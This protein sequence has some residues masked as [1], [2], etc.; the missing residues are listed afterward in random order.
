MPQITQIQVRRDTY[1]NWNTINPKLA[2]GE[3][4]YITSGTDAGKFK[5][6]DGNL[7]WN[8]LTYATDTSKLAGAVAIANGGTGA[9]TAADARTAL[10]VPNLSSSN[11]FSGTITAT[12]FVDSTL[13]TAGIVTNDNNGKLGSTVLVPIANGGT[14]A[15]DTATA[16]TNLDVPRRSLYYTNYADVVVGATASNVGLK[17]ANKSVTLE[18]NTVYEVDCLWLLTY[19]MDTTSQTQRFGF[20]YGGTMDK[21]S[22]VIQMMRYTSGQTAATFYDANGTSLGS[23]ATLGTSSASTT[24]INNVRVKALLRTSTAG[25]LSLNMYAGISAN[26]LGVASFTT[27]AGSFMRVTPMGTNSSTDFSIGAWS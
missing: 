9:T 2:Q 18:A 20:S 23:V 11:T 24:Y 7:L 13:T 17:F 25:S 16:R 26:A 10:N 27:Y 8:S 4:G 1:S 22:Y 5:I 15:A 21:I 12:D 19:T 6:G 3:I 14:N